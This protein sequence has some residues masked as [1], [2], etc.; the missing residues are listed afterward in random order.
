MAIFDAQIETIKRHLSGLETSQ[1]VALGLC[2]VIIAGAV[3]MLSQW[4]LQREMGLLYDEKLSSDQ[5]ESIVRQ[6]QVMGEEYEL[7]GDDILVRPNDR[8]R[9]IMALNARNTGPADLGIT[10][11]TLLKNSD[12]FAS[13]QT[14]QHHQNVALSNELAL[15]I[16]SW[17]KVQSARVIVSPPT[18]RR[19]GKPSIPT[20]TVQ[21]SLVRSAKM[22]KSIVESLARLVAGAVPG[23]EPQHVSIVDQRAGRSYVVDDAEDQF[24][25][26]LYELQ[27]QRERELKTKIESLLAYIPG[28]IAQVRLKL[29][30]QTVSSVATELEEPAIKRE[31]KDET[32]TTS[33]SSSQEPGV[34]ANTGVALQGGGRGSSST[35]EKTET[36]Y[37]AAGGKVTQVNKKPGAV[38]RAAASIGVPRSY[39]VGALKALAG[40][41]GPEPTPEDIVTYIEEQLVEIERQI[42]PILD[43]NSEEEATVV[44]SVYAD[45][46]VE[47]ISPGPGL[48]AQE[49]STMIDLVSANG[50]QIGL[51]AMA[52]LAMG[53]MMMMARGGGRGP[54]KAPDVAIDEATAVGPLGDLFIDDAPVGKAG[55]PD[56]F[57]IAQE[58][59]EGSIRT[60]Q[61]SQQVTDLVNDDPEGAAQLVRRWIEREL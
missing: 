41:S 31:V 46:A 48:E 12:T 13:A 24:G 1:R 22:D 4:S 8:R 30:E 27:K 15:M 60:R 39:F 54:K 23:L 43:A 14:K 47:F 35:K 36:D 57:L 34:S 16:Q 51:F 44:V 26:T 28:V 42:K 25:S 32:T 19:L 52:A 37:M 21:V 2:V 55:V 20:A 3:L 33:Q 9:L 56:A 29:D 53:L 49:A 58:T 10:F 6:L 11:E 18:R 59:D 50:K 45:R 17:S 5:T 38:L 7:R 61:I 40:E